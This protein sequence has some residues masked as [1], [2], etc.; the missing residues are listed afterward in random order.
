MPFRAQTASASVAQK[1]AAYGFPGV[2]VDGNDGEAAEVERWREKDPLVRARA[3]LVSLGAWDDAREAALQVELLD[4]V[5]AAIREADALP[6]PALESLFEDV[7]ARLPWHL[8]EQRAE[9]FAS[10]R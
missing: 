5:N 2:K 4:E 9:L 7:Y 3:R 8:A 10:P 6:P 1:A